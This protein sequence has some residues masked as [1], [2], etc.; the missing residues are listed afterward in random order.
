MKTLECLIIGGGPA[1]LMA[2]VYLARFRR[3]ILLVDAGQSRAALIPK[4]HNYPGLPEGI[5][6][7]EMLENL[8]EQAQR[9]GTRIQRGTVSDLARGEHGFIATIDGAEKIEAQCVILA[10]GIVDEKPGLPRMKDFIY[11]GNVRFCPICDGYEA[12]DARIAVI[13]PLRNA[14][15]KALFLRSYS[16]DI[17][18]LSLEP[19]VA[20]TPEEKDLLEE[21]GIAAPPCAVADLYADGDCLAADLASGESCRFDVLYPAM[22]AK[23]RSALALALGAAHAQD[24]CICTSNH[25]ETSVPGLYAIGDISTELH[26][27]SVAFGH[28]AL[29]ATHMHNR[30]E[31]NYK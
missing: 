19:H 20:L 11:E 3:R 23:V 9:Y 7:P 15:R 28:A 4:S 31:R 13:G 12:M 2:A 1:G 17:T 6:G 26:Q 29:A 10:S 8:R 30:L 24:G 25:C 22:D 14:I 16:R 21:A 18:I 27:I 5:T